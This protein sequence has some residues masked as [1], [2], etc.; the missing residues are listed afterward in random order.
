MKILHVADAAVV[1]PRWFGSDAFL[2]DGHE[3]DVT[4]VLK[5]KKKN[6]DIQK[7]GNKNKMNDQ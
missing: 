3:R 1:G 5:W 4:F 7:L 2:T 6:A